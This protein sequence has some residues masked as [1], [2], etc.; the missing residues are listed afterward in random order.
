MLDY[1]K[2]RNKQRPDVKIAWFMRGNLEGRT[3]LEILQKTMELSK[4]APER[5]KLAEL[6]S[7]W[8]EQAESHYTRGLA[9]SSFLW[10]RGV[11]RLWQ[12]KVEEAKEDFAKSLKRGTDKKKISEI[13]ETYL[14]YPLHEKS[15]EKLL[16]WLSEEKPG[17]IRAWLK[18]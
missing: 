5:A 3:A 9:G 8:L 6:A 7:Y 2:E 13:I 11:V 15:A 17:F 10:Q 16:G 18:H 1:L 4:E 14:S 12:G